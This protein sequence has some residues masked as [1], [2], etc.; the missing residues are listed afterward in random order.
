MDE[1]KRKRL[2][3]RGAGALADA[4]I[5][6]ARWDDRAADV[7]ERLS[8]DPQELITKIKRKIAG[9]KRRKTFIHWRESAG[10]AK[11]IDA[12]LT[13]IEAADPDPETGLKLMTAFY[14]T[15]NAV[16]NNCD[17]S[18]G[19]ISAEYKITARHLFTKYASACS[20][21]KAVLDLLI[22]LYK[23]DDFSVRERLI[24]HTAEMVGFAETLNAIHIFEKLEE[25]EPEEYQKIHYH[26]A[27]LSLARQTHNPQLFEK[28]ILKQ[29]S[30]PSDKAIMDIAEVYLASG[31]PGI[32]L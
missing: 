31:K 23:K 14:E 27:I 32:A 29:H 16:F 15:D 7:V 2:I 22:K 24:D 13:D 12:I 17:D 30:D 9:L 3:E 1:K 5:D 6:L 28:N 11:K 21:K 26:L 19:H 10:F 20:N 18:S 4:L 8:S 25:Q